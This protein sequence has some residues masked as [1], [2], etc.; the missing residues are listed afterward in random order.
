[1]AYAYDPQLEPPLELLPPASL[2]D[3]AAARAALL[4]LIAPLNT[5]VD[6][7]GVTVADH[8]VPGPEGASDVQV[9]I[10]APT[11]AAS[12]AGRPALLD[13]HGGGFVVGSIE[14][15]HGFAAH[16]ARE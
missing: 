9:R 8:H 3:I 1:M 5:D 12:A 10:Y 7:G 15:E 16:L 2:D 6:L 14:M 13:I 4:Q 11:G